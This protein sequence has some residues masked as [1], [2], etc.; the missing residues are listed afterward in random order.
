MKDETPSQR[1]KRAELIVQRSLWQR[2]Y[3]TKDVSRVTSYDILVNDKFKVEV[4]SASMPYST[5][6]VNP[7]EFDIFCLV[8]VTELG[9]SIY[10]LKDKK[11]LKKIYQRGTFGVIDI[12]P[13]NIKEYFTKKPQEA[14]K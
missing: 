9:N 6:R 5:V 13:E 10:Y 3:R 2:N 14:F 1:G 7:K 8:I 12:N 11:Y 4:K